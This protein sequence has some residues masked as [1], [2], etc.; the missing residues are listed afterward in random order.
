MESC[1]ETEKAPGALAGQGS[2]VGFFSVFETLGAALIFRQALRTYRGMPAV[3][4]RVFGVYSL[5]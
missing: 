4:G 5:F 1:E 2:S 3:G